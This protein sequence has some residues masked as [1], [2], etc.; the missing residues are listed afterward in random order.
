MSLFAELKRRNVFRVGIAYA[1][2]AWLVLQ[3]AEVLVELLNLPEQVG[4]VVVAAVVIGFP[5]VLFAAWA[6]EL[7]PQGIKRESEVQAEDSITRSTGK[8]LNALIIGMMAVA[9][10]YLL[11]DKFVVR[12][13]AVEAPSS[14]QQAEAPDQA[15][16]TDVA[17]AENAPALPT[18]DEPEIS[19]QSI[20]V[21]PFTNRS[22]VAEDEFFIDG[23][24]DDLLTNLARIGGIK[25]ISRTS[26]IRFRDTERPIPEIA[27]ELGVAT[28]MEGAVQ[29]AGDTVRINVQLIDAGTDEHLWAQIYDR[30][31]TTDNL[32]DIQS[33]ISEAIAAAL[34]AT[35]TP[36]EEER[37]NDRPTDNLAAYS[38]YLRGQRDFARRE[39]ASLQ[40]ALDEFQQA[41]E[42]DPDFALAW[43]GIAQVSLVRPSWGILPLEEALAVAGPAAARA[44]ALAPNLGEARLAQAMVASSREEADAEVLYREAVALLPNNAAAHQWYGNLLED[45][46]ERSEEA[47][48]LFRKALSLDPLSPLYR[49]QVAR[50]LVM[51]GRFEEAD[52]ELA[53]VNESDPEFFP[54]LSWRGITQ[55]ALGNL[56]HAVVWARRSGLADPDSAF[57]QLNVLF[58]LI[59]LRDRDRLVALRDSIAEQTPDAPL[60][61]NLDL[62]LA[63]MEGRYAGA[64]EILDAVRGTPTLIPVPIVEANIHAWMG[65][66]QKMREI[67]EELDPRFFDLASQEAAIRETP[68]PACILGYAMLRTGDPELGRAL[69][70]QTIQFGTVE[71]PRYQR[72]AADRMSLHYCYAALGD[73]ESA[74]GMMATM[75]EHRHFQSWWEPPRLEFFQPLV[76][77]P[78]FEALM[79]AF[80]AEMARQRANLDRLEAEAVAGP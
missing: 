52:R 22:P 77:D 51:L 28:V 33:E 8:K 73:Q 41:V 56:D 55:G 58:H 10:A 4:P 75:L 17:D 50:F 63:I 5:V 54:A 18:G 21:L 44:V 46:V 32:F 36:D 25:V 39:V 71:L 31:L 3:L 79:D 20:A 7:T 42:L 61:S 64:L 53:V 68:G 30:P 76:G 14:V 13:P 1:V 78:R 40:S 62:A 16:D 49:H 24:H 12:E 15:S 60:L 38:A 37:L 57:G 67:W 70:D 65:Q 66:W 34:Q 9:I 48:A 2:G 29:R 74:L 11:F 26:V 69:I 35:L 80:D 6:Y 47:L 45:D 27:R 72:H 59:D 43:A 23:I 19:P